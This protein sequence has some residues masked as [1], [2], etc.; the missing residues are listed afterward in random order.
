MAFAPLPPRRR[1]PAAARNPRHI[2]P[3]GGDEPVVGEGHGSCSGPVGATYGTI[4]CLARTRLDLP[5]AG[6]E[7]LTGPMRRYPSSPH[8]VSFSFGPGPVSPAIK[9]LI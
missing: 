7:G 5:A 1:H 8:S 3:S 6:I 4:W 2:R 9:A